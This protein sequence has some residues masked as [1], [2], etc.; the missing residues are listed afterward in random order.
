MDAAPCKGCG[1][2]VVGCHCSC[3]GYKK[4]K[5]EYK[6]SKGNGQLEYDLYSV[7]RRKNR[8]KRQFKK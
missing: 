3:D 2:R 7:L 1:E 4:W 6:E 5:A 8:S